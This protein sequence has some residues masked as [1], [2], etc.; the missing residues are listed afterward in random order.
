VYLY[1]APESRRTCQRCRADEN[2]CM[3][4]PRI[5]V[6]RYGT[7][8]QG[9][10]QFYRH[11]RVHPLTEW[12][13]PAFA[14]PAEAG[15][16]LPTYRLR[17]DGRLSWPWVAGWLHTEINVRHRTR[18]CVRFRWTARPVDLCII[19]KCTWCGRS[20]CRRTS[21]S[22]SAVYSNRTMRHSVQNRQHSPYGCRWT[23]TLSTMIQIRCE[24]GNNRCNVGK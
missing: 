3:F 6:F 1:S 18:R 7:R 9:I 11:T 4:N 17:R 16:H 5:A 21:C 8:S 10:S 13:I 20:W 15:T 12:T 23:Y 19:G 22:T 14:F 2:R 24:P